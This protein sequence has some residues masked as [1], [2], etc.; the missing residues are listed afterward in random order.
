MSLLA[1]GVNHATAPIE[2]RERISFVEDTVPET[3]T[4][5]TRGFIRGLSALQA[6]C[7]RGHW[8]VKPSNVLL[9]GK[10]LN[11]TRVVLTDP[12]PVA[13]PRVLRRSGGNAPA[14]P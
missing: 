3:L 6:E 2:L 7:G 10:Q 5:L 1:F 14:G 13:G 4:H 12:A 9:D 11:R 8:N